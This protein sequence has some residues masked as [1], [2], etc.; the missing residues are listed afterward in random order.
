MSARSSTVV[1]AGCPIHRLCRDEVVDL[2]MR[3]LG[4]GVGGWIVTV[5]LD[6]LRRIALDAD[7]ARLCAGATLR[8]ADG[9]PLVWASR[10][11]GDPLPGR[12][13]GSDLVWALSARAAAEG[14][15]V[16][17]L[18]GN[19][20]AAEGAARRLEAALPT[21]RLAGLWCPPMGFERDGPEVERISADVARARPDVVYVALGSPKQE[22]LIARL[23]EAAP[24]AWWIGVGISLSFL[25]GEVRRAPAW[26]RRAGLEWAHRLAQE[27]GRLGRRYLVDGVPFATRLLI[28]SAWRRERAAGGG[29]ERSKAA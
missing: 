21:L 28:D 17:L 18:G 14:R 8:V 15:S 3:R 7:F 2:A 26:M 13:C 27:P 22:R 19:P 20:G 1:L 6:I 4:E 11:R 10:L 23:R 5:N 24:Q 25:S 12:V 9:M 16:Y 29:E